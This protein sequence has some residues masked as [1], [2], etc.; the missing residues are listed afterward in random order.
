MLYSTYSCVCRVIRIIG[1]RSSIPLLFIAH[2]SY[3]RTGPGR[4]QLLVSRNFTTLQLQ[5]LKQTINIIETT[6]KG[7]KQYM[8]KVQP[9]YDQ[10]FAHY[11]TAILPPFYRHFTAILPP[12]FR[13][14]IVILSQFNRNFTAI[15]LLLHFSC[16]NQ[17]N[18]FW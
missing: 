3:P 12:F 1:P 14:F 15:S 8:V 2:T 11:F 6:P 4:P 13:H 7:K 17:F 9:A 5:R 18:T 16:L 10:R